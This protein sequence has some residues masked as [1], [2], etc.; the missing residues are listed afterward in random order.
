MDIVGLDTN[1]KSSFGIRLFNTILIHTPT[2][3]IV[4]PSFTVLSFI[5]DI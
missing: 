5:Y 1:P 3:D 2:V 4:G